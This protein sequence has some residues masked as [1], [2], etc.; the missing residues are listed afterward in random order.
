MSVDNPSPVPFTVNIPNEEVERMRRLIQ[1]TRLPEEPF[2]PEA[3]WDFGVDLKWLKEM[4]DKWVNEFDWKKVESDMNQFHHYTV[5][6]EGITLHFIHE[7]SARDDAVP[8]VLSHGWPG[9]FWDFHKI[10]KS[11]TDPPSNHPAFHVVIPSLPGFGFSS[12]P[13]KE[14][15]M[16]DNARVINVLMTGVLGYDSYMAQGGDL[17]GVITA[18]LGTPKFP[19]C[20]LI[21]L[22][23][24]GFPP[25][26]TALLTLPLFLFPTSFRKWIYSKIYSEEERD[27]FY[28]SIQ[29][30][31]KGFAYFLQ[32]ATRPMTIGYALYD[33]PIGI[34][35]WIGEKFPELMDP[36][37]SPSL[38]HDILTTISIY[39]LTRTIHTA[40]LPYLQNFQSVQ[41]PIVTKPYGLSRFPHD[42]F[43]LPISWIHAKFKNLVFVRRHDHGGHFPAL[44][45]P[46]LLVGDLR[47]MIVQ[48]GILFEQN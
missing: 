9:T 48:N 14:W 32:Q 15:T 43:M 31:K 13:P 23:G 12:P 16:A 17:G 28:R 20:K 37:V 46:D 47:E 5:P 45:V 40:A 35:S 24:V 41:D 39:Y 44:E 19:A 38:T 4:K 18:N 30:L 3:S 42:V 26:F 22:N 10:L 36:D 2:V 21:N 29:F 27:D 34:L 33:S 6:I 7:K 8:I 11:L 25:P 1:D